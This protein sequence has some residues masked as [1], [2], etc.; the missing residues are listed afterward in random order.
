MNN[1]WETIERWPAQRRMVH[2]ELDEN[3]DHELRRRKK[4]TEMPEIERGDLVIVQPGLSTEERVVAKTLGEFVYWWSGTT[5]YDFHRCHIRA[6][7]RD[8]Q[9]IWRRE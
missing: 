3:Y 9:E 7:W 8:A 1:D 6:I 2:I 4:A 5:L